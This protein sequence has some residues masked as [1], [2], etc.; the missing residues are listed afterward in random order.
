M[1]RLA[2]ETRQSCNL[3]VLDGANVRVVAQV[4]SPGDFGFRVRVGAAFEIAATTSGAVLLAF[5]APD[6]RRFVLDELAARGLERSGLAALEARLR[7]AREQGFLEEVDAAQAGILD[8]VHPV[9]GPDG[10]AVAA[11]TVPCVTTSYGGN[12]APRVSALLAET[13]RELG[14]GMPELSGD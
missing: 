9:F 8:L 1:Q 4:E 13:V 7:R 2:S 3:S 5:A 12:D 6:T 10:T 14:A 11:L